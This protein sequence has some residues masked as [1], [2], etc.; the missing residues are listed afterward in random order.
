MIEHEELVNKCLEGII[1][2]LEYKNNKGKIISSLWFSQI[3]QTHMKIYREKK[4][5]NQLHT[6]KHVQQIVNIIG[7]LLGSDAEIN[8]SSEYSGYGMRFHSYT[9]L[10]DKC[11]YFEVIYDVIIDYSNQQ[12]FTEENTL[13]ISSLWALSNAAFDSKAIVKKI[14]SSELDIIQKVLFILSRPRLHTFILYEAL[15]LILY[16]IS[17]D[18]PQIIIKLINMRAIEAIIDLLDFTYNDMILKLLCAFLKSGDDLINSRLQDLNIVSFK[19]EELGLID[20]LENKL[21]IVNNPEDASEIRKMIEILKLIQDKQN[22]T[23]KMDI[24]K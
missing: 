5:K 14:M 6:Y 16:C 11:G 3:L 17:D 2:V 13:A 9:D 23:A 20:K 7:N 22:Y 21:Q 4:Q 10:I 18:E 19:F 1:A 12:T 15:Y 8:N 24:T